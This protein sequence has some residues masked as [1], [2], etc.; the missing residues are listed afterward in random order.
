MIPM[1][2]MDGAM[3]SPGEITSPDAYYPPPD[4]SPISTLTC[5]SDGGLEWSPAE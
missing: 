2:T 4:G 3:V 1:S 5:T